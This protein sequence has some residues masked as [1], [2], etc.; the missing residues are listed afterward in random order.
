MYLGER[1]EPRFHPDSYGYR[2]KKAAWDAVGVCRQRCWKNDWVIDLDVE[3]FFD[4]VPWDLIVKA[5][6]AVTDTP[7]VLLYVKRWL[8]APLQLHD[9]TIV[10]RDKGTPQGSAVSPILANLYLLTEHQLV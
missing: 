10:E 4:S 8:A 3:K 5:V 1:A 9:G 6:E 7:W 2:P